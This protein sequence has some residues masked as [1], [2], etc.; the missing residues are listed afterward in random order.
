MNSPSSSR[1]QIAARHLILALEAS[2][3]AVSVAVMRDGSCIAS[4]EH[5]AR[6]G[7]A[8]HLVG[9]V[10]DALA[11]AKAEFSQITHIAAGCGPGSFTGL[12][13]CLAAAKG[14]VL[15]TN[16][17]P[18]GVNGLAALGVNALS[19]SVCDPDP[20]SRVIC[21]ADTRR[22]SA[23]VQEF[24]GCAQALSSVSDIPFDQLPGWL[25]EAY[26]RSDTGSVTLAGVTEHL[27]PHTPAHEGVV[28]LS[29]PVNA[30]M[31]AHYAA[32]ALRAPDQFPYTDFSPLYVVAPKLGPAKSQP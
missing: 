14:Y 6:F 7:H 13:V 2:G 27:L 17:K 11:E 26:K 22:H 15:A 24:D 31:I 25:E 16:A 5:K 10:S 9:L 19:D 20:N 28:Q 32:R 8:E 29:Q 21:F 12:R 3:D 30:A 4:N 1:E 23:F 18:V